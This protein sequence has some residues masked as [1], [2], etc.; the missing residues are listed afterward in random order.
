MSIK[1]YLTREAI[2]IIGESILVTLS[3]LT[4]GILIIGK[5]LTYLP[6]MKGINL[7]WK[8][9][10]MPL[11]LWFCYVAF[12]IIRHIYRLFNPPYLKNKIR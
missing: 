5:L 6:R 11:T 3:L 10:F 8:Y 4:Q 12:L 1:K 9:I 7:E 2:L